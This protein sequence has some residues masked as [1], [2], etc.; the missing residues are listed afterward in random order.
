MR[1][2]RRSSL[3]LFLIIIFSLSGFFFHIYQRKQHYKKEKNTN[4]WLWWETGVIDC[5]QSFISSWCNFVSTITSWNW[6]II[7]IFKTLKADKEANINNTIEFEELGLYYLEFQ[8]IDSKNY[9]E[10]VLVTET[11]FIATYD[12][13]K[14]LLKY[15]TLTH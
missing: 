2:M 14:F 4:I 5:L 7:S 6:K 12:G 13:D 1:K 15:T 10:E 9:Y 11:N 3:L 8:S